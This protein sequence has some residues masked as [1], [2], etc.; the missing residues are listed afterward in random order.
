LKK[1]TTKTKTKKKMAT[2]PPKITDV[3]AP[4][5]IT[6]SATSRPIVVGSHSV[7]T[8]DPMVIAG[9]P[10]NEHEPPT[11]PIVSRTAK[12]ISPV[13]ADMQPAK[14][15]TAETTSE[16]TK[17]P[18]L[19]P[20]LAPPESDKPETAPAQPP[21]ENSLPEKEESPARPTPAPKEANGESAES[22]GSED[23]IPRDSE[24][25][26]AAEATEALATQTKR[27][28]ELEKIIQAGTYAVPIN[29]VQRKRSR[30]FVATM[31]FLAII[32][33]ILLIDAVLDAGL[34]KLPWAVPHTHLF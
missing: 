8:N 31:C 21:S 29:A 16:E 18:L 28:A 23:H 17:Q 34:F 1:K 4:G 32:L 27:E 11:A 26:A 33:L 24:A 12:T 15:L 3:S 14:P 13:S 10:T 2:N 9:A 6:P 30:I 25:E 20:D 5:K 19:A 22:T 7:L